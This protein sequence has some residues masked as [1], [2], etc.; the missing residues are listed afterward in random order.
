M[1]SSVKILTAGEL[2]TTPT[3]LLSSFLLCGWHDKFAVDRRFPTVHRV[4]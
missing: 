3:T 1:H 4:A 2:A